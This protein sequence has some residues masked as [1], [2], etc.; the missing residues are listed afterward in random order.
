MAEAQDRGSL[1]RAAT[2]IVVLVI[3]GAVLVGPAAGMQQAGQPAVAPEN[4]LDLKTGYGRASNSVAVLGSADPALAAASSRSGPA[5]LPLCVCQP[6]VQPQQSGYLAGLG[7]AGR[8]PVNGYGNPFID[9]PFS[10]ASSGDE[11]SLWLSFRTGSVRLP[12]C[13]CPQGGEQVAQVPDNSQK[14]RAN[15]IQMCIERCLSASRNNIN[16]YQDCVARCW[17]R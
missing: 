1:R 12:L 13:M 10:D 4:L 6:T 11:E 3:A 5:R 14:D 15:I 7:Y 16:D 17:G 8:V 2:F 9:S